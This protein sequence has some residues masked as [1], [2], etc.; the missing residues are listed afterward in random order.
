MFSHN[1]FN[2]STF[3]Y[4]NAITGWKDQR[5]KYQANWYNFWAILFTINLSAFCFEAS[6][7]GIQL[8]SFKLQ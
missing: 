3:L 1:F 6:R 8:A 5:V 7:F 4:D 2:F